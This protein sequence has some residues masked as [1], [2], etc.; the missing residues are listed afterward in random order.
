MELR[1]D[2]T[3][4]PLREQKVLEYMQRADPS[5]HAYTAEEKSRLVN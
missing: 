2:G 5:F 4:D 3:G 1:R